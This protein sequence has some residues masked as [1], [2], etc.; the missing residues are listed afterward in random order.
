MTNLEFIRSCDKTELAYF[1]CNLVDNDVVHGSYGCEICIA[2]EY[3]GYGHNGFIRWL[4]EE[5]EFEVEK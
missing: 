4:D 3:C 2:E 5:F 1:L